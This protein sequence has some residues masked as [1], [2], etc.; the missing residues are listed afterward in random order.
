MTPDQIKS[1][2]NAL[3]LS[4]NEF[5]ERLGYEGSN[6]YETVEKLETGVKAP[7]G[8]VRKL[9]EIMSKQPDIG[10]EDNG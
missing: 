9:L 3:G 4:R 2:R 1:L 5:G 7:S 6:V 8:P 10:G